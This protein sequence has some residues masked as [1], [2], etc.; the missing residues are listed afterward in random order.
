MPARTAW[1]TDIPSASAP[2]RRSTSLA[3]PRRRPVGSGRARNRDAGTLRSGDRR[4]RPLGGL[5]ADGRWSATVGRP[6]PS[7]AT[8]RPVPASPRELA[9]IP[10]CLRLVAV[11]GCV[12]VGA[13]DRRRGV[14]RCR[15]R[16]PSALAERQGHKLAR[17]MRGFAIELGRRPHARATKMGTAIAVTNPFN[18]IPRAEKA[19]ANGSRPA[20][21]AAATPLP[22]MPAARP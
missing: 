3:S 16:L 19:A 4:H 7:I 1:S 13:D 5:I 12:Q 11:A 17:R 15:D 14:I 20:T 21:W 10:R 6:R 8:Q 22:A 18:P 2:R 9:R